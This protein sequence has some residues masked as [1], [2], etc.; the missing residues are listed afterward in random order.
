MRKSTIILSLIGLVG[1]LS[2]CKKEGT[3][4][5]LSENPVVPTI[6]TVPD[7]TFQRA[8]GTDTVIFVGTPVNPGFTA[9]AN[10]YLEAD[11]AGDQFQNALV[12]ASGIQD[13]SF[14]F[15][16]S[17][18]N[19]LLIKRFPTDTISS[20]DFRI[21]SVLAT[22]GSG[23]FVSVSPAK[24]VSVTTYGLPRLELIGSGIKQ[25]VE[26]P[27]GDGNYSGYVKLDPAKAFTLNDPD[28]GITYGGASSVLAVNGAAI[29]ASKG[30]G[31]YYLTV[32]TNTLSFTLAP[33]WPSV[34]GAF[35]N[36]GSGYPSIPGDYFMDYNA[37]LGYWYI[38]VSMPAGPMKFRL[39]ADWGT[40][41][42]PNNG[43]GDANLPAT[44]GTMNLPNS[45]GNI[46]VTTAGT[47]FITLTTN[48]SAAVATF[49]LNN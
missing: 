40:N 26:S 31:W 16:V 4:A 47:Y 48:G 3:Q 25:K 49:T 6:T 17:D 13:A 41:W 10:Y 18:L 46:V 8:H 36:W 34:V 27:L 35:T 20:I 43:G 29:A 24:T 28:A 21:R 38:T 5:V 2:S 19:G 37:K 9:S 14:K 44:G 15:S 1:I 30:T 45:S 22:T 11:T 33:Y 23:N 12:L 32:N 39:N 42:G 7:M